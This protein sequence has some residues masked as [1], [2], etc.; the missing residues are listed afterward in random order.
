MGT[1]KNALMVQIWTALITILILKYLK[2]TSQFNWSL[3]NLVA[4][5]RYNLFTYRDLREWLNKPFEVPALVP[6]GD[7]LTL[8]FR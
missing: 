2:F 4:M 1:S 8:E 7:Q 6:V 3:S 5:L